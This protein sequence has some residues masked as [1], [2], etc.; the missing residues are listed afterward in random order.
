MVLGIF[1][2]SSNFTSFL[3]CA[4]YIV[5]LFFVSVLEALLT[6]KQPQ[7]LHMYVI[8]QDN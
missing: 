8:S 2:E 7:K 4:L 1:N 3:V 5:C 6:T